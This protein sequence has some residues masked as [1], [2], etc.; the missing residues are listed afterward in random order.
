MSEMTD[1]A[2]AELVM[3][4]RPVSPPPP[5]LLEDT[6]LIGQ[7]AGSGL[8]KPPY[9]VRRRD[10][11]MVQL[12]Q[13]LYVIAGH[14]DGRE[15]TAIAESAGAKLEL[16][17]TPEQVA[18][19]AE[20]KLTPLGLIAPRDGS[21]PKLESV[22]ALLGLRFR[23][24]LIPERVVNA[25]AGWLR[26]LFFPP[27]VIVVLAALAACDIWLGTSHGVGA[28]LTALIHH[29]ALVLALLGLMVVSLVFHEL[30]HA[31]ACRY[32][33][34]RPGR[35]GA[36]LYLVWP[37]FYTDVT[38]SYRLNKTGRLRTDLGGVYFNALVALGATGAYFLTGYEP[39]LVLVLSQQ[40]LMLDQ[41]IP[42]LRL[43]GYHIIRDLIGVSDLFSRIK[44]IISSLVPGRG[45][46][47]RVS[48]LK[49]WA[50]AAVTI[51]VLSTVLVLSVIGVSFIIY[52]PTYFAA[53]KHS[54]IVQLNGVAHAAQI[55]SP[56]NLLSNAI[57]AVMLLLPA[58]STVLIYLLL[59][60]G[61][62]TSLAHR[63]VRLDL[64]LATARRNEA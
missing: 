15:L 27:L 11:Q 13:L 46:H 34:A 43:D 19:V 8:R 54:L 55:A 28:G 18:Y 36:G 2:P 56:V 22:N 21:A 39:L 32:G 20:R 64:T 12:S 1:L 50:R 14:M 51:W 6:E 42:W 33:G 57:G 23:V 16:R 37:A 10:G 25:L 52:A 53:A 26:A 30:G 24:R 44:P 31:A 38:D 62:G 35:I 5:R 59:C 49:P 63:R 47:P 4:R 9:L 40:L 58:I 29:P 3:D 48:E 61:I 45:P 41:F 60:R 17:I 7:V